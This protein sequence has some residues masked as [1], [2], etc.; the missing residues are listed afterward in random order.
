MGIVCGNNTEQKINSSTLVHL[1]INW[2]AINDYF[3]NE[4]LI[5]NMDLKTFNEIKNKIIRYDSFITSAIIKSYI[6]RVDFHLNF[7]T[8]TISFDDDFVNSYNTTQNIYKNI[9]DLVNEIEKQEII[10]DID[11]DIFNKSGKMVF[12]GIKKKLKHTYVKS[13]HLMKQA[14]IITIAMSYGYIQKLMKR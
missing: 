8:D 1:I 5:K 9:E 3:E 2:D 10:L 4:F 12:C 11:L 7:Q 13:R 6:D 14:K